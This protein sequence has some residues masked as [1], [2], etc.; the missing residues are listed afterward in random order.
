MLPGRQTS[1]ATW[2]IRLSPGGTDTV[3][4]GPAMV[5][6]E[7]IGRIYGASNPQRPWASCTVD[8][9]Y[10]SSAATASAEG[11]SACRTTTGLF[12]AGPPLLAGR[13]VETLRRT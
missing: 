6:P 10:F 8:T 4:A 11:C 7:K 2:I 9:P 12:I 1:T 13:R 3:T 5:A